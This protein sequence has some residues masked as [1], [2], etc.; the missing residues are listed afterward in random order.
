MAHTTDP[1]TIRTA[2]PGQMRVVHED[3][4]DH[5]PTIEADYPDIATVREAFEKDWA[6]HASELAVYDD[7]GQRVSL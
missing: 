1:R 5:W 4:R 7:Q 6:P 2:P 3:V